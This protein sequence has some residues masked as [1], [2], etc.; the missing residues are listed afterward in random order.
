MI[1]DIA[2]DPRSDNPQLIFDSLNSTGLDL[3]QAD[4]IRNYVLMGQESD[5]QN[6]LYEIWSSMEQ[7]F[8][9]EYT[10]RFGGFIRDYLTLK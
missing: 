3:S 4:R 10:E 6:S 1:V 7:S 9:V 8:G 5:I 2:L